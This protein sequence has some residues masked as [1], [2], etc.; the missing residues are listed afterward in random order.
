M[1]EFLKK[2]EQS[3]L[4]FKKYDKLSFYSAMLHSFV[5]RNLISV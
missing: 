4:N 1:N 5:L 2:T 3:K